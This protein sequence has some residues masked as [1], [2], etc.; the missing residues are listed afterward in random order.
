MK[1]LQKYIYTRAEDPEDKPEPGDRIK[2]HYV[3]YLED[4]TVFDSS[5]DRDEPF[6][7]TLGETEVIDGWDML[8]G[9]MAFGERASLVIPPDYAYGEEGVPPFIPPDATLLYDVEILDIGRPMEDEP[10]EEEPED[11]SFTVLDEEGNLFWEKDPERE[12]GCGPG[13]GWQATGNDGEEICIT[14]PIDKDTTVKQLNID[15][16]TFTLKVKV[17][18]KVLI[19]DKIFAE[20]DMD[21]SHWDFQEKKGDFYLLVYLAKLKGVQR[22]E[23]LLK[24]KPAIIR[25]DIQTA[26]LDPQVIDVDAALKAASAVA[27]QGAKGRSSRGEVVDVDV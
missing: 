15:V 21:E 25:S 13:Y 8:C 23:S 10:E 26:I 22:W 11:D 14:I 19:D 20:V 9:T 3:G 6:Q 18:D 24:D 17:K 5:R 12:S 27:K 4:G 16:R 1:Q 7:F 2:M